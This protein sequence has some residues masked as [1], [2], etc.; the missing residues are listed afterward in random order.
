MANFSANPKVKTPAILRPRLQT[1][2]PHR[3]EKEAFESQLNKMEDMANTTLTSVPEHLK[4]TH[5]ISIS[6]IRR[7]FPNVRS[8]LADKR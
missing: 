8:G 7:T 2:L 5:R 6:L 4:D 3:L 1:L